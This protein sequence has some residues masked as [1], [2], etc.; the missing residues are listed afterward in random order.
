[1]LILGTSP[2]RNYVVSGPP[3]SEEGTVFLMNLETRLVEPL[4]GQ[5]NR[6]QVRFSADE[7]FLRYVSRTDVGDELRERELATGAER[8]IYSGI[9]DPVDRYGEYW[10][11]Q[12]WDREARTT[13]YRLISVAGSVEEIAVFRR[14]N[15]DYPDEAGLLIQ[16]LDGVLVT[17][18]TSFGADFRFVVQPLDGGAPVTF[19]GPETAEEDRAAPLKYIDESHLLVQLTGPESNTPDIWLL[20]SDGTAKAI[21]FSF[22]PRDM[23]SFPSLPNTRWYVV[24][25]TVVDSSQQTGKHYLVWDSVT[26]EYVLAGTF[27]MMVFFTFG[28]T[29]FMV[30]DTRTSLFYRAADGEVFRM[31]E[32]LR[33]MFDTSRFLPGDTILYE[34]L[35]TYQTGME[36][37]L[38]RYDP[39]AETYTLMAAGEGWFPCSVFP[40]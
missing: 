37:G 12:E 13:T 9:L 22:G 18:D 10:L 30:D 16:A 26:F 32:Q 34:Q 20:G 7:H 31:P 5:V 14:D 21:G 25:D 23:R 39:A 1:M 24:S 11:G 19:T 29:G 28:E 2:A 36:P 33:G 35:P 27:D 38:Y 40:G 17:Y 3:P 4:S 15:L 8:V 6:T